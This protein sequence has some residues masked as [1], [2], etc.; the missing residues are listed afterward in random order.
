MSQDVTPWLDEIKALRAQL[1]QIQQERD[2]AHQASAT[3]RDRLNAEMKLR[4]RETG[5]LREQIATL[6]A[7]QLASQRVDAPTETPPAETNISST[8]LPGP[9]LSSGRNLEREPGAD[10][11]LEI[12]NGSKSTSIETTLKALT[13]LED[14]RQFASEIAK[15]RDRLR[16]EL[17]SERREHQTTRE[18]LS[19]ALG[20]AIDLLA[21]RHNSS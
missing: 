1:V 14:L 2:E 7:A 5:L 15:E 9:R 20:D 12:E 4:V 11:G 16:Q 3:W 17:E 8:D 18:N 19:I 21:H 13:R 10:L 6:E